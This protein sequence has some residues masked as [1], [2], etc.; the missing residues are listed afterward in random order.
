LY[1]VLGLGIEF[2]Q[3][4]T[5]VVDRVTIEEIQATAQKYLQNPYT[6]IVGFSN[7]A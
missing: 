3:Q 5:Q 7:N 1:E 4:F 6:V 2:D